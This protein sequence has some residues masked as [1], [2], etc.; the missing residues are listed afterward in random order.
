MGSTNKGAKY[1]PKATFEVKVVKGVRQ[2]TAVNKRAKAVAKKLG[3]RKHLSM[4]ELKNS[5]G[6]GSYKFYAY[7]VKGDC[8][9][10]KPIRF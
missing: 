7:G 10:L 6:K 4:N 8:T 1:A 2:F 5:V 9:S 3:K